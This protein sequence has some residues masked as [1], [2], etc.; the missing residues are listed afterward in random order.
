M[1]NS[2]SLVKICLTL[3]MAGVAVEAFNEGAQLM[4]VPHSPSP[5]IMTAATPLPQPNQQQSQ[6]Q[7][8]LQ[9]TPTRP[10]LNAA[11][12]LIQVTVTYFLTKVL[13]N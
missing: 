8:Q 10:L 4:T 11:Q 1:N 2:T 6:A 12:K 3:S 5:K 13:N 9:T 7:L